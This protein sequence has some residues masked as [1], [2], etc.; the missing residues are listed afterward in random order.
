VDGH[1]KKKLW[2]G[3]I[4]PNIALGKI[5]RWHKQQGDMGY[6]TKQI[7][8]AIDTAIRE[9]RSHFRDINAPTTDTG[10]F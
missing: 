4:H 3:T 6:T 5:A 7:G 10:G 9:L 1:A 2:G 8:T